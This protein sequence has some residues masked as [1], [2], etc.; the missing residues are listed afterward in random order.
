MHL[1][2]TDTGKTALKLY[3]HKLPIGGFD[4]SN[5]DALLVSGGADKDLRFWDM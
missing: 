1:N 4:I 3:G 2:F 5:D